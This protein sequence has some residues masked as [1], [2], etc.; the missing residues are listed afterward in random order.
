VTAAA[1]SI[2]DSTAEA[3]LFGSEAAAPSTAACW[4]QAERGV[5]FITSSVILPPAAQ[6][7]LFAA[8]DSGVFQR[9]AGYGLAVLRRPGD[10]LGA[11]RFR[12]ARARAIPPGPAVAAE[13]AEP[14]RARRCASTR[15]TCRTCC[16]TTSTAW[17]TTSACRSGVSALRRRTGCAN[18]PWAGQHPRA[19]EPRAPPADPRWPRRRSS[20][21]RSSARLAARAAVD[22]PL[23][24]QDLLALPLRRSARALRAALPHAAAA[25]LRRQGR[26]AREARRDGAHAPVPEAA[27]AG[28]GL[29]FSP[30][31]DGRGSP[32]SRLPPPNSPPPPRAALRHAA[33]IRPCQT[34]ALRAASIAWITRVPSR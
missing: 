23:V 19:Q 12:I 30:R 6:R 34:S 28:S 21:P 25:A 27:L 11:A 18:Y 5:L 2:S 17:W 4:E 20:W 16:A 13:R 10:L 8:I 32:S 22:E 15:R 26:A 24:K 9:Q 33:D 7:L 31:T 3:T 29:P 14:A 1:G